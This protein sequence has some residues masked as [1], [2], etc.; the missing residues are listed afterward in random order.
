MDLQ[1]LKREMPFKWKPNNKMGKKM[2]CVAYIDARQARDLLDDV[3]GPENWKS[4]YKEVKGNVYCGV[5]IRVG[6]EWVWKWDCGTESNTERE[7]GEA[8][9]A[10]KRACVQWG[11]GRFLY[12]MDMV[13]LDVI[14]QN[15]KDRV[16]DA[17]GNILWNGEDI[18]KYINSLRNK[19]NPAPTVSFSNDGPKAGTG[20]Y[21]NSKD[22]DVTY[23][24]E[25]NFSEETIKKVQKLEKDGKKGQ[26]VL[27]DHLTAFNA[28]NKKKY[29]RISELSDKELQNLILFIEETPPSNI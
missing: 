12:E 27:L 5:G 23:Q 16:T 6:D 21:S 3:V 2:L 20:R 14:N 13:R 29:E 22:K 18:T 11:I 9:D 8:S 25:H 4:D 28:K 7:K 15:G 26:Q 24:K 1:H 17:S 19:R 10:F